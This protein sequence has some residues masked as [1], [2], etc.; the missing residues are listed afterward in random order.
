MTSERAKKL[1]VW[2][3]L[4]TAIRRSTLFSFE[5]RI[6]RKT[7][8][9]KGVLPIVS[10]YMVVQFT[11]QA[12]PNTAPTLPVAALLGLYLFITVGMCLAV[13]SKRLHDRNK[14]MWWLGIVFVPV[15][16]GLILFIE[17]RFVEGTPVARK[18]TGA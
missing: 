7:Y 13:A 10:L 6:S 14:S 8:W 4:D 1:S 17:L 18:P 3:R 9:L 5:G 16:G 2:Y 12:L 15:V 11:L